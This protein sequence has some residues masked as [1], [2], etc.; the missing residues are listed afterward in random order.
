MSDIGYMF[1][2][3]D[4]PTDVKKYQEMIMWAEHLTVVYPMWWGQMPAI[5]KGFIDRVFSNGFAY[6]VT[7]SG[8]EGLLQDKTAH[9]FINTNTPSEIYKETLMHNAQIRVIQEAVFEF[10]GI[11]TETTFFGS[12]SSGSNELREEYLNSID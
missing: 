6:K 1:M 3:K 10:C 7:A 8:S 9:I 2:G 11:K 12:V 4:I 5:L